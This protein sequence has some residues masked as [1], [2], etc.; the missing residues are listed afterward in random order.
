[1]AK[2][3]YGVPVGQTG[4][5]DSSNEKIFDWKIALSMTIYVFFCIVIQSMSW[6]QWL[7]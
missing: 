4:Y 1:L 2:I 6:Q 5:D 3:G 7:F